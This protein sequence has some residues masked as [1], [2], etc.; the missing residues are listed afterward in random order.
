VNGFL[1]FMLI[2]S[3]PPAVRRPVEVFPSAP[4]KNNAEKSDRGVPG[5]MAW[6]HLWN[7]D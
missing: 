6:A 7:E 3:G 5:D 2:F 1:Y 4:G